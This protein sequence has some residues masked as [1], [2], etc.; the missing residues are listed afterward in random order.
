MGDHPGPIERDAAV[1]NSQAVDQAEPGGAASSESLSVFINHRPE[2]TTSVEG[3]LYAQ[4]AERFGAHC[5]FLEHPGLHG[6]E[7]DGEQSACEAWLRQLASEP[8][9]AVFIALIG[10]RWMEALSDLMGSPPRGEWDNVLDELDAAL[11]NPR[12]T[13]IPILVGE[14]QWPSS[15]EL[16]P[17]LGPLPACHGPTLRSHHLRADIDTQLIPRLIE[18]TGRKPER[19]SGAA[20]EARGEPQAAPAARIALPP[21]EAHYR[22]V[23]QGIGN[24]VVYLGFEANA[25]DHP[26][27]WEADSGVPPDDRDLAA[28]LAE[29]SEMNAVSPD[30][31]TVAQYYQAV[32]T[33]ELYSS[34]R[35]SLRLT[36]DSR[37]GP[38]HTYLAGLPQ[39][40]ASSGFKQRFQMIVTPKYDAALERAFR[41]AGEPFDVAVYVAPHEED[42]YMVRGAFIHLPWTGPPSKAIDEPNTYDRFPI[43]AEA[44]GPTLQRTIIVRINGAVEDELEHFPPRNYVITED[45][46][47]DYLGGRSAEAVVPTQI[48]AMLM[49]A[50]HLFLGY[51]IADWRLR[52]FL[53]LVRKGPKVAG[54][55][56]WAIEREPDILERELWKQAVVEL[57]QCDLTGYLKG[58]HDHLAAN[59]VRRDP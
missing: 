49:R 8:A 4:L 24:L 37:P 55:G 14:V 42:G 53:R 2:G 34:L 28:Y 13:V 17:A 16:P 56:S 1:T 25:D 3:Q 47:I 21:D 12:I 57:R 40:L 19:A 27:P 6:I 35:R 36:E 59:P 23:V 30:L 41:E 58:L 9:G 45:D 50:D 44:D 48:L 32:R 52:V 5:V 54:G 51:R 11:R 26:G 46:Y 39:R 20:Q 7:D 29:R 10:P 43:R 31:A 15:D 38:V 22:E 18:L 33:T